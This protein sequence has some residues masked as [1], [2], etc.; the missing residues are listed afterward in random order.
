MATTTKKHRHRSAGA[1]LHEA[2]RGISD[3]TGGCLRLGLLFEEHAQPLISMIDDL[4]RSTLPKSED[5]PPIRKKLG[6]RKDGYVP[7]PFGIEYEGE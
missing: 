3:P 5:L 1:T 6:R 2:A 4:P 7:F